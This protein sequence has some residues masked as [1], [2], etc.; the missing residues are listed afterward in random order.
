VAIAV[1][2]WVHKVMIREHGPAN[3]T[4]RLCL[5]ALNA[6]MDEA[7]YAWPSQAKI[8]T[9]AHLTENTVQRTLRRAVDLGW[10]GV[11]ARRTRG[12]AWKLSHYKAAIPDALEFCDT[13]SQEKIAMIV[14]MHDSDFGPILEG[15]RSRNTKHGARTT[16]P[17]APVLNCKPPLL[18]KNGPPPLV[19]V[20]PHLNSQVP[21]ENGTKSPSEVPI[22]SSNSK[23]PL[24][25]AASTRGPSKI[26]SL[27]VIGAKTLEDVA[28]TD[29]QIAKDIGAFP[30]YGDADLAKVL[31][32]PLATIQR[33]RQQAKT[34][35]G[36]APRS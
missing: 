22:L 29:A 10:I 4:M 23:S 36:G 31:R 25:A 19:E 20:V 33:I 1:P 9:A 24:D 12:K 15:G 28:V 27:G 7:G 32:V 13:M 26:G 16:A 14:S 30:A 8:A 5:Y 18:K 35:L 21:S 34:M 6:F 17:K 11:E 2:A 3:S